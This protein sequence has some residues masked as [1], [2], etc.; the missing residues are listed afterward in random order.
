MISL[1]GFSSRSTDFGGASDRVWYCDY[2]LILVVVLIGL[3]YG[4]ESKLGTPNFKWWISQASTKI[5]GQGFKFDVRSRMIV[6]LVLENRGELM[7]KVLGHERAP[8]VF[9][10]TG[11]ITLGIPW[12]KCIYTIFLLY[13]YCNQKKIIIHFL[14]M[15]MIHFP[16]NVGIAMS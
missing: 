8:V 15:M 12:Y 4:Y 11:D 16:H 9:R 14:H 1:N 13:L 7:V 2:V 3:E 5:Y 6:V 10:G